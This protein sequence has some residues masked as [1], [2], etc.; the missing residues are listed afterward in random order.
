VPKLFEYSINVYRNSTLCFLNTRFYITHWPGK[1]VIDQACQT[2]ALTS[3]NWVALLKE[4]K[5][6]LI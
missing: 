4:G 6:V 2:N 1:N 3:V 5:N